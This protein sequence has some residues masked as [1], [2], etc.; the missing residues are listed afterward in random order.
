MTAEPRSPYAASIDE[1]RE[2]IVLRARYYKR[3]VIV[4]S[5][6]IV[7]AVALA[8]WSRSAWALLALP[9]LP[10]L[11]LAHR[12]ADLRA[13]HR[14]RQQAIDRWS[15]AELDL[16]LLASTLAKVP[17]L[18]A[19]TVQGMLESLPAWPPAQAPG[20]SSTSADDMQRTQHTLG[21]L[22]EQALLAR[23]I[24]WGGALAAGVLLAVCG[25]WAGLAGGAVAIVVVPAWNGW[26]AARVRR[27]AA[28]LPPDCR[29]AARF[30]WNG[31]PDRLR[32]AWPQ[33]RP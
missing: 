17:A 19:L 8:L 28:E 29:D 12:A 23:A 16:P 22:A 20:A 1:A 14:W 4:V 26:A 7:A 27:V 2:T 33:G 24:G 10:P 31:V 32:R 18:P 21:L 5:L 25:R 15:R 3:L 9:L 30:N 11:V 13:V 6:G